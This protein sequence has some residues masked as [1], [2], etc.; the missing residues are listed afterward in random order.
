MT[1]IGSIERGPL[2]VIKGAARREAV[3]EEEALAPSSLSTGRCAL[4]DSDSEPEPVF[5]A[6]SAHGRKLISGDRFSIVKCTGCGLHYLFPAPEPEGL[7]KYY[8]KGYYG[9]AGLFNQFEKLL[10]WAS[11][12]RKKR[13][14]EDYKQGG[15]LLD[16]GSGDGSFLL[17]FKGDRRWV[18]SGVEPSPEGSAIAR[19][20]G[21]RIHSGELAGCGFP[22]G[23]FDAVTMWHVLEHAPDPVGL[24]KDAGRVLCEGGI[25]V[26]AFPNIKSAGF[27]LG[28]KR[29]FHLDPP[30]HLFHFDEK[31]A[32]AALKA[33]GLRAVRT[34]YPVFEY[35]LDL[36][37]SVI[38][39][40]EPRF[41][42]P[43]LAIPVMALTIIAKPALS[44]FKSS[45]TIFM[46]CVKD[47]REAEDARRSFR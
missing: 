43:V 21:L 5:E 6:P 25:L 10:S 8:G 45:E 24:L 4:C 26:L 18:V 20:R 3:I 34:V 36:F 15:R 47:R 1:R 16:V 17:A 28:T 42:R 37:H 9:G 27:V 19:G 31:T 2:R 35:P 46:V 14:I 12:R 30:R 7:G 32:G 33:A 38:N 44:A 13:L 39:S 40:I 11:A 29:W 23:H 41:L 22:D